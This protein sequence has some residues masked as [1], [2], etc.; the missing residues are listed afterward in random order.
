MLLPPSCFQPK[1]ELTPGTTRRKYRLSLVAHTIDPTAPGAQLDF[2]SPSAQIRK[3]ILFKLVGSAVYKWWPKA[4]TH[5][6]KA[7]QA[8]GVTQ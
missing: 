5:L 3:V 4:L 6:E 7:E 8:L 2:G 1:M